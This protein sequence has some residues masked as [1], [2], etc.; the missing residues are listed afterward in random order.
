[1]KK[2]HTQGTTLVEMIVA[3][4]LFVSIVGLVTLSL[5]AVFEGYALTHGRSLIDQDGQYL[6]ARLR[7]AS[8]Q[9]DIHVSVSQFGA[10]ELLATGS[11]VSGVEPSVPSDQGITLAQNSISGTYTSPIFKL[12]KDVGVE[13]FIANTVSPEGTDITYQVAVAKPVDGSCAN[14]TYTFVGVDK[15]TTTYFNSDY[16]SIPKDSDGTGYENPEGCL[17]YKAFL[18]GTTSQKPRIYGV[19]IM[20]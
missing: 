9:Q 17:R 20:R 18:T 1:M 4:T 3:T 5:T 13:T 8:T 14:A 12:D 7:F 2:K 15:T 19:T 10:T 16:F 6:L 11:S